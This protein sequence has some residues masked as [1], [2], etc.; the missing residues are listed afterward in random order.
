[1]YSASDGVHTVWVDD[2]R[3]LG[4]TLGAWQTEALGAEIGVVYF[5]LGA[6]DP[7]LFSTLAGRTP[8]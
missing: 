8:R 1:V 4:R 6:E 7:S 2:A 5:G 3:S